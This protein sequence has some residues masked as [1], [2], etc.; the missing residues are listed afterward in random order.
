MRSK[1]IATYRSLACFVCLQIKDE[2]IGVFPIVSNFIQHFSLYACRS[3]LLTIYRLRLIIE[4]KQSTELL[5]TQ[6]EASK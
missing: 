6:N 1:L 3:A 5:Y 2:R 4:T